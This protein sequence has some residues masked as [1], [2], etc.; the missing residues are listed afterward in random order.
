MRAAVMRGDSKEVAELMRQDPAFDVNMDRDGNGG[1]LLQ[2]A[3]LGSNRSS[4]IPLLLAHPDI[5]V[6]L[7][8]KIGWTPFCYASGNGFTSCV[9][10]M[11]KDSRVK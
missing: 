8:D 11:L 10:E 1:T 4:V 2:Y 9:R 5:D 7:K 6:N 3:C